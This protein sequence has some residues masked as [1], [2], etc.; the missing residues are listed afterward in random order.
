MR[1][2]RGPQT[3]AKQSNTHIVEQF[4]ISGIAEH[5]FR[6]EDVEDVAYAE[7]PVQSLLLDP[8][9]PFR[10]AFTVEISVKRVR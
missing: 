10:V 3:G 4:D 2:G 9:N 1:G 5:N 6:C 7:N 8:M